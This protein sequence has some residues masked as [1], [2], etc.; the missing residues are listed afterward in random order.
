LVF[1]SAVTVPVDRS[2]WLVRGP[3][4][5]PAPR[6]G[7]WLIGPTEVLPL[8]SSYVDQTS[9]VDGPVRLDGLR[10]DLWAAARHHC[11]AYRH[12]LTSAQGSRGDGLRA[13]LTSWEAL[14]RAV[15]FATEATRRGRSRTSLVL[16]ALTAVQHA[17]EQLCQPVT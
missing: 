11:F 9:V 6:P 7:R 5:A 16:A 13:A 4:P 14:P 15:G 10:D 3:G 8:L 2:L 17:E 12:Q 1:G